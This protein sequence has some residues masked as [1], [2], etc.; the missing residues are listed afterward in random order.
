MSSSPLGHIDHSLLAPTTTVAELEA[1]C[2]DAERWGVA[3]VCILPYFVARAA[4]ALSS[5]QIPTC[6][7]IGFPHGGA[8]FEAKMRETEIALRDG[9]REIDAVTNVSRLLSGEWAAIEEELQGLTRLT[10]SAGGKIKWIFETCYLNREQ[11]QRLCELS[12]AH[13]VDWVKTSTGFGTAGATP[14]DVRF[15]REQCP[16]SVQV[17]ASGGIRTLEEVERYISLGA[18]RIGTSRTRSIFEALEARR[19]SES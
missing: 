17:K 8:S 13:G 1:A 12:T 7:V 4:K 18:S 14:E 2:V 3:S 11:K 10:Q 19:P 15:L 5:T 16:P 6:T 9:A